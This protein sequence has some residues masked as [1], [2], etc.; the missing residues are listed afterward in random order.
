MAGCS[1][2]NIFKL[3]YGI[4]VSLMSRLHVY[5]GRTCKYLSQ[6][7]HYVDDAEV[8][9]DAGCGV[10]TFSKALASQG[11]LVIA[12]DIEKRLLGEIENSYI[13]KVCADAHHLPFRDG[14]VDC[15]ISLTS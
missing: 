3:L 14:S 8:I 2:V 4:A 10:G 12:L 15:A 11:R 6:F 9:V 5:E 1:S 7:K 13:E